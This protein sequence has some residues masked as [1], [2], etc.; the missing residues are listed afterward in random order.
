[1]A[2][3]CVCARDWPDNKCMVLTLTEE[4]RAYIT[5]N[6]ETAPET[7]AY[8]NPCWRVLSDKMMGAQLIKSTLQVHLRKRGVANAEQLSAAYFDRLVSLA[9]K[10]KS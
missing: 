6:G 7:Y 9:S 1:M 5:A 10:R 3:C 8:C 4:E 2:R